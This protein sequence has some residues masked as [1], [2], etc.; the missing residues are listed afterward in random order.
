VIPDCYLYEELTFYTANVVRKFTNHK[1][2]TSAINK[3][4][5]KA[6]S[7]SVA[8]VDALVNVAG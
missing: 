5:T 8:Q 2:K 3:K 1:R 7:S 6:V 4:K